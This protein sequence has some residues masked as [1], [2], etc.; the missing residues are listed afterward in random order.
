MLKT[1]HGFSVIADSNDTSVAP[2]IVFGDYYELREESFVK[3]ILRGGDWVISAGSNGAS[4]CILAAQSVG[5]FGRVFA[6]APH[7]ALVKKLSRSAAMNGM[8]DRVVVR[9]VAAGE[10]AGAVRLAAPSEGPS[11]VPVGH[12]KAVERLALPWIRSFPSICR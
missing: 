2:A 3:K 12:H 8:H 11:D 5:S 4:F 9:P 1:A 6:Y 10:T 7:P